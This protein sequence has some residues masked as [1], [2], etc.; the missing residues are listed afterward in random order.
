MIGLLMRLLLW[1]FA[2]RA[3]PIGPLALLGG[4]FLRLVLMF[5]ALRYFGERAASRTVRP[6]R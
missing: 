6:A 5:V 2:R 3:G 4:P 1:R